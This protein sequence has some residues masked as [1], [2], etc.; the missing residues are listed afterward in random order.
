MGF[1]TYSGILGSLG[2]TTLECNAVTFVLETLRSN[3]SLD[4]GGFGIW[5]LALAFRL[6]F[7]TNNEFADL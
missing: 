1:E 5:L 2:L 6:D 3:E 7:A 4:L